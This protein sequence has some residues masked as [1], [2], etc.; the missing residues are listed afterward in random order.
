M[1]AIASTSVGILILMLALAGSAQGSIITFGLVVEYSGAAPPAEAVPPPWLTAVFK[2]V[3]D[4][5]NL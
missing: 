1:K 2:D 3:T 5:V 4:G